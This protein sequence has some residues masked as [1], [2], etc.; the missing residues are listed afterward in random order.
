LALRGFGN[1]QEMAWEQERLRM[2]IENP[3]LHLLLVGFAQG[4]F[5]LATDREAEVEWRLA[6]DGDLLVEV[7][8]RG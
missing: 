1:L 4:L 6:E 7:R 3:C 8:A 2:R 5:E